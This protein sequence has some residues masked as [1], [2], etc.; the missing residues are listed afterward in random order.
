MAG[1]TAIGAAV[2]R[3]SVASRSSAW[4]VASRARKSALAGAMSTTS[5]QR[6]SSMCPMAASAAAIPQVRAHRASGDRLEGGGGD[7][8]A[9]G[10]GHHHLHFRAALAQAPHEVGALVGRDAAGDAEQDAF[11]LHAAAVPF[12]LIIAPSPPRGKQT[13]RGN[14]GKSRQSQRFLPLPGGPRRVA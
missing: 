10:G 8:L 3:H 9:R 2:A 11:A 12:P 6:A 14:C 1:A 4:P 5:A 7:E 13:A